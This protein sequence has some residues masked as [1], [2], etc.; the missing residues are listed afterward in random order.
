MSLRKITVV[1]LVAAAG[2]GGA[3]AC[4]PDFPWQ[5]LDDR[6]ATLLDAPTGLNFIGQLR[7]LVSPPHGTLKV[8]EHEDADDRKVEPLNV[9][10]DEAASDVWRA[11]VDRP[12]SQKDYSAKLSAA[13]RARTAEQAL[14]ASEGLPA[15]VREYIAGAVAFN[16]GELDE[17]LTHFKAIDRLP[18]G[19]RRLREV[20]AA[21]MQA[22]TY[23]LLENF[24]AASTA[25]QATRE[26]ALAGA[27]DPMGLGVASLGDEAR[28]DLLASGLVVVDGF[29]PSDDNRANAGALIARAVQLYAEQAA[30]GSP[31]ARLSLRE[32]ASLLA[33]NEALLRKAVGDPTVRRLLVAYCIANDD[34]SDRDDAI[35]GPRDDASTNVIEALLA[36]PRPTAGDDIDRL[37]ML[38]YQTGRYEA[39]EKLTATTDRALGLW[40]RAKL[41]FRRGD[42]AAAIRDLTAAMK[43]TTA[44][45]DQPARNRLQGEAA[46]AKLSDGKYRESLELLFPLAT[47]Y[48][49]DVAYVAERVLT[50]D[51]LKAFVDGL[52]PDRKP[53]G[54]DTQDSWMFSGDQTPSLKLRELLARRLM[55]EGRLAEAQPYFPPPAKDAPDER[56]MATDYRSAVGAAQPTWRWRD[57]T[58]V[59]ALFKVAT[60]TRTQGMELMG[61]EGPPDFAALDGS[62]GFGI[63]QT[64]PWG[65]QEK[66][67]DGW[68]K[69]VDQ[70]E[71]ERVAAS[72]PKPDARFHYRGVAADRALEA[73]ALLPHGSQAYAATL[74]WASRYAKE[75]GDQK[76]AWSIYKLYVATGPYQPWAKTFGSKCPD[77][78]FDGARDYWPKRIVQEA[79]RHPAFAAVA[80]LAIALLIA[81]SVVAIR[82]RRMRAA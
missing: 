40:V 46:V 55:R 69:F 17:A 73:A 3:L 82:R 6:S 34:Q 24:A 7:N 79:R 19:Q 31:M 39:A 20:A 18:A 65:Q 47:T 75:V 53:V 66:K 11:L 44:D 14:A 28:L 60:L 77:P 23:Q 30:R 51:E 64:G 16:D 37:A 32:V 56:T 43:A 49:G 4:G 62:F 13:R 15:A 57:V 22:R 42:R 68:R 10:Q 26:R 29:T 67:A 70:T 50:V 2:I 5:L 33:A 21:Y 45:L 8:V 54:T 63:G 59:E 25:Y 1:A 27:P 35:N 71:I 52:P 41:G 78:D 80:G 48:W 74:C 9:E 58:R 81:G 36:Q 61:T 72:A 38:A 12:L 76:R